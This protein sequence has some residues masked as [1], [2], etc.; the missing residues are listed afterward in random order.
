VSADVSTTG[1][2]AAVILAAGAS[3]RL[4]RPKQDVVLLGETMVERAVRI[5]R[6]AGF[7]PVIAVLR[8]ADDFG[9]SV[10]CMGA[11]PV[12]NDKAEEGIAASIRYGVNVAK[13]LHAEGAVLMTCD[14]IAVTMD[15][16]RA[17]CA[18]PRRVVGSGYAGKVGIPA[19]FPAARFAELLELEGDVGAR[20]MLRGAHSVTTEALDFDVDTE[21]DVVR[22]RALLEG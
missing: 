18:E 15:H 7:A 17:L 10:Q 21:E 5:A 8:P 22:A 6:E 16:L 20:E 13:M 14:Q 1:R 19:Y 2:I 11:L 12:L 4:G 3:R 9:Y